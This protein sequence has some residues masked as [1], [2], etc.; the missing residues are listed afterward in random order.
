MGVA[1]GLRGV[2]V[3]WFICGAIA[4]FPIYIS[5][6]AWRVRPLDTRDA[7]T[8]WTVRC[9]RYTSLFQ[10]EKNRLIRIF[11]RHRSTKVGEFMNVY[12]PIF[13]LFTSDVQSLTSKF[14]LLEI[15]N[16]RGETTRAYVNMFPHGDI[17][18]LDLGGG[19]YQRYDTRNKLSK[20]N[21]T[22]MYV[23]DQTDVELLKKIGS[24]ATK[25]NGGFDV[26]IDDGGHL[27]N[28][29]KDS[30]I[31][32]W[33]FVKP[34]GELLSKKSCIYTKRTNTLLLQVTI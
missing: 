18:G 11:E 3:F 10:E 1:R 6:M 4:T 9:G 13:A 24:D 33:R 31:N 20:Y 8:P 14:S 25:N 23:G 26:V 15:G 30:L 16:N 21:N 22:H 7:D 19:D 29:Q 17:Y 28:H 12:P 34:G 27:M 5:C 2:N 32:L